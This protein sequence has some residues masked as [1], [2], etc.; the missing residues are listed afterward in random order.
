M[1]YLYV[2]LSTP[3]C[4]AETLVKD[5]VESVYLYNGDVITLCTSPKF[6]EEQQFTSLSEKLSVVPYSFTGQELSFPVG[7][8]DILLV[9]DYR[10]DVIDL[11]E[12]LVQFLADHEMELGGIATLV[13]C[14]L[15]KDSKE[16]KKWIDACIH[17]T[18]TV[19]LGN[20]AEVSNQWLKE[21]EEHYTKK[22][23]PC[24][25]VLQKKDK[26][27]NPSILFDVQ[28]RRMSLVFDDLEPVNTT[29]WKSQV[30][31]GA[32]IFDEGEE[33]EIGVDE[34]DDD[35]GDDELEEDPYFVRHVN[36]KRQK[37]VPSIAEL[38]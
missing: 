38:F 22:C 14:Q 6:I 25:F 21:F 9:W 8:E 5:A 20:R 17:F 24:F 27:P 37:F 29:D 1:S 3:N 36:G 32:L 15:T 18:D 11:M 10:D 19:I 12:A 26:L 4:G 31:E 33:G 2:L 7:E 34:S 28:A 30:P 23:Y 13:D 35:D 16:F